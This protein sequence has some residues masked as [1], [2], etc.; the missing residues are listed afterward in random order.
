MIEAT[1]SRI[2]QD[3]SYLIRECLV[4]LNPKE[5]VPSS[6]RFY[7]L[8]VRDTLTTLEAISSIFFW[9]RMKRILLANFFT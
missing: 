8:A 7:F 1:D 5:D 6:D 2:K 9:L 3:D 4:R